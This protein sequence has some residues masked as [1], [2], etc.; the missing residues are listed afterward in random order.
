MDF[1]MEQARAE[2]PR[3]AKAFDYFTQGQ[4]S[5]LEDADLRR[6]MA[7]RESRY[8]RERELRAGKEKREA[9]NKADYKERAARNDAAR[10]RGPAT[11]SF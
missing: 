5:E 4:E 8:S 11:V 6:R 9:A 1:G 2:A 10:R 7:K 3:Q